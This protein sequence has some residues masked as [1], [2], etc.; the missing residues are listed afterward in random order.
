MDDLNR[1]R[2]LV[3]VL[4][5]TKWRMKRLTRNVHDDQ[6]SQAAAWEKSVKTWEEEGQSG[7]G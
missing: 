1:G 7:P 4:R 3:G 5:E 2:R 6:G